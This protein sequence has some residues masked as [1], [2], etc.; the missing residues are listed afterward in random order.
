MGE[1]FQGPLHREAGIG[2]EKWR[3]GW[4]VVGIDP[5]ESTLG[6]LEIYGP[7]HEVRSIEMFGDQ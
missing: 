5:G 6:Q 4:T 7:Q 3:V 2:V 1:N